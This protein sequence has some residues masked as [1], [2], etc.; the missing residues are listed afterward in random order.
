MPMRGIPIRDASGRVIGI[1][2]TRAPATVGCDT[3][4]CRSPG[5]FLC[6]YPVIRRG[7]KTTCSRR[8]CKSCATSAG[9]RK[10][11]C[12]PHAK[13]YAQQRAKAA[14]EEREKAWWDE[15]LAGFTPVKGEEP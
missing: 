10:H 6:D 3:T 2:C 5:V 13:L 14:A 8:M 4:A 12:P 15:F 9:A 7:R 1:G 11:Y